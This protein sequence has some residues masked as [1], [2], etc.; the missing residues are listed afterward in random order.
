MALP[1]NIIEAKKLLASGEISSVSLVK[2]CLSAIEEKNKD[3]NAY[4]EVY[5]DVLSQAK[6]ADEARAKGARGDLLGIPLAIK[7][8][9]LIEGRK[10]S[11]ASKILENY[12]ATYDATAIKKLK[13]SGA[14]FL[15]RTNMDE[16]AMGGSTENSAYGVTKNP[17]DE[18][19]VAGGSSG[20]SAAA[21][22]MEGALGALGTDT[23]GS[24]R[25]PAS[26]C[27]LV[28]LKPTYGAVSR[29][30]IM[31]MGSSLDQIGPMAKSVADC[32]IIFNAIKG[33]DPLD[34]TSIE[35]SD[36]FDASNKSLTIG[37]PWHFLEKGLEQ[38]VKNNF[39]ETI[40]KLEAEGVVFKEISLPSIQYS[41]PAYYIIMPAE[42]S[43]NLN[44]YDGVRF[45]LHKDGG[46]GIEDYMETRGAGFG[47][48]VRRR[49]ILGTYVLSAG[50]YYAYYNKAIVVRE[51]IKNDFTK[52]F[53]EVDCIMTPTS[54]TPAFK[55]GEK[56]DEPL[57][58]YLADIFTTPAN[59]TGLPALSVPS[60][61]T[62]ENGLPAPANAKAGRQAGKKL[63]LGI[64]LMGKNHSEKL[65][66]TIGKKIFG[67]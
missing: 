18:T 63:P 25:Q 46:N 10:A 30:G 57:T 49:I 29:Y 19:R 60:G 4:L 15:G 36:L 59:I 14:V 39:T 1:K 66:F 38:S 55:I 44:R 31:A 34:S 62:D 21:V 24:V 16:F 50:Y 9:I 13:N 22:A 28:G 48:E 64:Q 11:A 54:P 40:K 7:D 20:G 61:F 6:A 2:E 23:G 47:P 58:M 41:L 52:V 35:I 67:Q 26:F 42:A 5:D 53:T 12:V 27:G 43:T 51:Q 32:E 17:H 8:N 3:I 56:S 45:G 37:I 65:L 33:Q